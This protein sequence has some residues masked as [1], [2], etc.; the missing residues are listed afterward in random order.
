M[1]NVS[2]L[3]IGEAFSLMDNVIAESIEGLVGTLS[4]TALVH[5]DLADF[6]TVVSNGDVG[7]ILV[8]EGPADSPSEVVNRTFQHP[9]LASDIGTASRGLVQVSGP[10]SMSIED[11]EGIVESVYRRMGSNT[12]LIWGAR[13]SQNMDDKMRMMVLLNGL[14]YTPE[15]A[16]ASYD[17][18]KSNDVEIIAS[19]SISTENSAV[20]I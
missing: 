16:E 2:S 6:Q 12:G 1:E 13:V 11:A 15:M 5:I 17:T 18:E 7:S 10:S 9:L 8:G 14:E 4:E 3:P 19:N 20:K